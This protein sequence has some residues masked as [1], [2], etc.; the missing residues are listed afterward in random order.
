MARVVTTAL[1]VPVEDVVGKQDG[2]VAAVVV[3]EEERTW[4]ENEIARRW[5]G[6]RREVW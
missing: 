3:F 4:L 2:S 6:C 5:L 1:G